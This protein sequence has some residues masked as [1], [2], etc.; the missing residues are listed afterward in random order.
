MTSKQ[1]AAAR[2]RQTLTDGLIAAVVVAGLAPL[3]GAVQTAGGW[4]E[5]AASWHTWTWSIFQAAVVASV[6]AVISWARRRFLDPAEDPDAYF[7][8]EQ[9]AREAAQ[10][11]DDDTL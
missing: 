11:D 1:I 10:R 3:V 9:R 4:A 5:L 6:T 2:G 7:A 8:A